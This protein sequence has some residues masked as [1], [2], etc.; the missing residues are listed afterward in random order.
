MLKLYEISY[1][2][3]HFATFKMLKEEKSVVEF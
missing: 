2:L 3:T 1:P